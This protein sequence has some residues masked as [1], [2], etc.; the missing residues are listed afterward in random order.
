MKQ[1]TTTKLFKNIFF[2]GNVRKISRAINLLIWSFVF[3]LGG[4]FCCCCWFVENKIFPYLLCWVWGNWQIALFSCFL[5]FCQYILPLQTF[6]GIFFLY[7]FFVFVIHFYEKQNKFR[8]LKKNLKQ[9]KQKKT[10][11]LPP[12]LTLCSSLIDQFISH[13]IY[14]THK[15]NNVL[16]N[17]VDT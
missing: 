8:Q 16:G 17:L 11:E 7:F 12:F 3:W 9:K 13:N 4:S 15:H 5:C 10:R 14:D 2:S 6:C 1:T